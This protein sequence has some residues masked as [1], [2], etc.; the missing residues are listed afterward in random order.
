MVNNVLIWCTHRLGVLKTRVLCSN[1]HCTA[2][3]KVYKDASVSPLTETR[4]FAV[5]L[6]GRL[7]KTPLGNDVIVPSEMAANAV[8]REWSIQD[9]EI[10]PHTMP[11]VGAVMQLFWSE[12][13]NHAIPL[14]FFVNL[15]LY[16]SLTRVYYLGYDNRKVYSQ[17][18]L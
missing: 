2:R 8:A 15:C 1:S 18:C 10:K 16:T 11:L 7:L 6:D 12:F 14:G 13:S 4:E 17:V 3:K 9:D 5:R